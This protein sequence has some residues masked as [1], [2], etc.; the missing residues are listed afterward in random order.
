MKKAIGYAIVVLC[1]IN[2][3][4][5]VW[6]AEQ[7]VWGPTKYDVKERYGRNNPYAA[8]FTAVP[9]LAVIRLQNGA[10]PAERVDLFSFAVNGQELLPMRHSNY[11]NLACF[12]M[13]RSENTFTL[14]IADY[15]PPPLRRP[16]ATPKNMTVS[17]IPAPEKLPT[18]V[19]GLASWDD[20]KAYTATL[21]KIESSESFSLAVASADL[22]NDPAVRIDAIRKLAERKDPK[23]QDY[24]VHTLR[25]PA[26]IAEMQGDAALG[27]GLLGDKAMIPLLIQSV[28]EPEEMIRIGAARG[29]SHYP[30]AD[31]REPLAKALGRMD[32]FMSS[33]VLRSIVNA[34]WQPVGTL[35][36]FAES[37]DL[38]IA[39]MGIELL[40]GSNDPRV[41]KMLLKYLDAPGGRDLRFIIR[42]L[43]ESKDKSVIAPLTAFATDPA[44]RRGYEVEIGDALAKL[45]DPASEKLI[46]DMIETTPHWPTRRRLLEA[47]KLLTGKDFQPK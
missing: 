25:D 27:I 35:I 11:N 5:P 31:T 1:M 29:L 20:L 22:K 16:R 6:A 24:L 3:V 14:N 12:V 28:L 43:G 37:S 39:N 10:V 34:G 21:V 40:S 4:I 41:V 8:T 32:V 17:V 47:Y 38:M 7:T 23:A 2:V 45:G 26:G 9:G 46:V 36:G 33:A 18:L 19:L 42:S 30:E 15:V 44:K 13:L